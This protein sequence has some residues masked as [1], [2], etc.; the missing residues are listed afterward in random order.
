VNFGSGDPTKRMFSLKVINQLFD[1]K[2]YKSSKIILQKVNNEKNEKKS[3][4][5]DYAI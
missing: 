4:R 3:K 5:Y 1:I 2:N